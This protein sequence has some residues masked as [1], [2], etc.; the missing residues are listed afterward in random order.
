M[1]TAK[2]KKKTYSRINENLLQEICEREERRI[3]KKK[4]ENIKARDERYKKYGQHQA[5]PGD[6]ELKEHG[7]NS[8]DDE[9]PLKSLSL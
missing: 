9:P 4:K 8:S 5:I 6:E 7:A 3:I 1:S 2:K